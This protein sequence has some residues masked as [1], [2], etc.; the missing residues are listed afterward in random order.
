[1][2]LISMILSQL[3]RVSNSSLF[4]P[5]VSNKNFPFLEPVTPPPPPPT[6]DRSRLTISLPFT[7]TNTREQLRS[8]NNLHQI[9][10]EP[11]LESVVEVSDDAMQTNSPTNS[12]EDVA[13]I[14]TECSLTLVQREQVKL[15]FSKATVD[16][17]VQFRK[18]R[19]MLPKKYVPIHISV[20]Y[21]NILFS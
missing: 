6:V 9:S 11:I 15:L 20:I 2:P 8:P 1:M 7:Y 16:R 17:S 12:I 18:F 4:L 14:E 13:Q 5:N 10:I 3:H 19:P 21:Q